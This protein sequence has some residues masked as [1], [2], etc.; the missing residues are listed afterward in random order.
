[1]KLC[2]YIK[3]IT[4]VGNVGD[5]VKYML[6]GTDK[7][8]ERKQQANDTG[9]IKYYCFQFMALSLYCMLFLSVVVCRWKL[10]MCTCLITLFILISRSIDL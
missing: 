8:A 10:I 7:Q 6:L 9:I 2:L 3:Y 4:I 1:M 5:L